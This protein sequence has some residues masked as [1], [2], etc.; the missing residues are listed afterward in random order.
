MIERALP[1]LNATKEMLVWGATEIDVAPTGSEPIVVTIWSCT[2][3]ITT[4]EPDAPVLATKTAWVAGFRAI[5]VGVSW[6]ETS[7]HSSG[8]GIK[9]DHPIAGVSAT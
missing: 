7:Q 1:A 4:T 5:A 8:L 9:H 6:W 3:S 2:P